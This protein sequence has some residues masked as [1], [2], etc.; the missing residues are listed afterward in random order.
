MAARFAIPG[1][2]VTGFRVEGID[3]RALGRIHSVVG[4]SDEAIDLFVAEGLEFVGAQPDA[5]EFLEIVTLSPDAMLEALD[6]GGITDAKTV[7]A[8]MLYMRLRSR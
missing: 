7:A 8:L 2:G 6:K 1:H 5:G 3:G 4:Y